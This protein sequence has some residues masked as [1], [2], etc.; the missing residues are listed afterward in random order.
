[1]KRWVSLFAVLL[2]CVI[3]FF[4][5]SGGDDG[6]PYGTADSGAAADGAPDGNPGY[7]V[8]DSGT[9]DA[10]RDAA[11]P[12]GGDEDAATDAGEFD[13]GLDAGFDAGPAFAIT[14]AA[15]TGDTTATITYDEEPNPTQATTKTNYAITGGLTVSGATIVGNVV[16]LTTSVQ[17]ATSYTVTV[18]GV[19]RASDASALITNTAD[20]TGRNAFDVSSAASGN[21]TTVNVTFDAPPDATS[22]TT[23][24]NYAIAGLTVSA[25]SLS[26][27]VVTL[28][29]STQSASTYSLAVSNVTRASDGE[30]LSTNHATFTGHPPF[31][32]TSATA[33]SA[34]TVDVTYDAAPNS[35]SAVVAANY[36]IAGLTVSSASLT[37]NVVT[38]TTSAQSATSFTVVVSN[39][40]R[41]SDSEPL[42]T[43]SLNFTGIAPFDVSSASATSLTK[44]TVTYDAVPDTASATTA[45]NYSIPGLTVNS[46]T[47]SGSVATLTTTTQSATSYELTVF[48]VTRA[49]DGEPLTTSVA[50][51][52]QSSGVPTVTNVVVAS[53]SPDN[54]TTPYNTGTSTLTIT[55]TGFTGVSCTAGS[56]GVALDDTNGAATPVAVGTVAT[57]CSVVSSTQ[58]TAVFPSGIR[59]NGSTGW[60]VKVTNGNGTNT[61]STVKFVPVAGLVI[62]E[63][64]TGTSGSTTHEFL[65]IYNPTSASIDIGTL[66]LVLHIRNGATTPTDSTKTL[67]K[68]TTNAIASHGFM[69]FASSASNSGDS[70][71]SHRD[72]TYS[73]GSGNTLVSGGGVYISLSGTADANVIDKVGWGSQAAGGYEGT[74]VTPDIS[75]NDSI[76]RKFTGAVPTD[77]DVNNSDFNAQSTTLAHKGTGDTGL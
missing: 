57:S 56:I 39:V 34:T 13:S 64:Y 59:T 50:D 31:D 26:G 20:F 65:S 75:S 53:T 30:A 11:A 74:A 46:V 8:T 71:Y 33:T 9:K 38:L 25:A 43:N 17:S 21:S 7:G 35:T 14:S 10:S 28:T 24:S 19:T 77:T 63:V 4:G 3:T 16:T 37:G 55:G 44:V 49:S 60:N 76:Q 22:A 2:V 15:S 12:D 48:N 68:I 6:S 47:L 1:M 67:T 40:T 58:I 52:T 36:A 61:T 41:A 27:S 18:T 66:G 69:L 70:W 54:G 5:C 23:A 32:I 62:S 51:F 72:S 45:T 73:S 42:T 29:T